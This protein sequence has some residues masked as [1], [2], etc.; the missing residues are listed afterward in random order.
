VIRRPWDP[1]VPTSYTWEP[2]ALYQL[3]LGP[4]EPHEVLRVLHEGPRWWVLEI[5]LDFFQVV[6]RSYTGRVLT[7]FVA[8]IW[9][10]DFRLESSQAVTHMI[11]T[12]A[13]V[14][15]PFEEK[16]FLEVS[17]SGAGE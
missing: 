9:S 4:L 7:V 2:G 16:Y 3:S 11:I 13:R 6:G 1:S 5:E 12:G 15:Y 8:R 10:G 17:G 14:A